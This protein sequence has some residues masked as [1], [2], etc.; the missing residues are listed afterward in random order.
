MVSFRDKL[1][2][3]GDAVTLEIIAAWLSHMCRG[4]CDAR[5]AATASGDIS[6]A[7]KYH[8]AAEMTLTIVDELVPVIEL[9]SAPDQLDTFKD[10]WEERFNGPSFEQEGS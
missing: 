1:I 4:A 10:E 7:L 5:N 6:S 8:T 9:I 2:E 3:K